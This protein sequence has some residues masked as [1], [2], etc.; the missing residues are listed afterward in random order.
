MEGAFLLCAMVIGAFFE[1][2]SIGLVIPFIAVL[3]EPDLLFKAEPF[4]RLLSNLNISDP[5]DLFFFVGP[6]L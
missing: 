2:L 6:A 5:R 4:R 3:N 1:A